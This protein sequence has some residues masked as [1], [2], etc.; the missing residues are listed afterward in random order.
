LHGQGIDRLAKGLTVEATADDGVIEA[1][2][3]T[4]S[5]GFTLAVQFHPEWDIHN[6]PI[7]QTIFGAFG[8]ACQVYASGR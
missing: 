1:V 6:N 3:V 8:K 5:K 4:A 2:S 7:G